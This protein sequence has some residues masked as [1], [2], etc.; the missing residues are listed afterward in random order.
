VIYQRDVAKLQ[1]APAKQDSSFLI[2][3]DYGL[4]FQKEK[5]GTAQ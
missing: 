2:A 4:R 5:E 3:R 1:I